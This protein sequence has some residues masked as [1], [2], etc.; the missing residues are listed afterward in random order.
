MTLRNPVRSL[1][2]VMALAGV[3][4]LPTGP[5][6]ASAIDDVQ[7][8]YRAYQ[9]GDFQAAAEAFGLAIGSGELTQDQMA[10]VLNNRGAAL[11]KAGRYDEAIA[12]YLKARQL[13]PQTANVD[14][15]LAH[16]YVQRGLR[17]VANGDRDRALDDYDQALLIDPDDI[18]ALRQRGLLRVEMHDLVGAA[19]DLRHV[20][21]LQPNDPA[22]SGALAALEGPPAEPAAGGA[23]AGPAAAMATVA[24]VQ[25]PPP[26]APEQDPPA[27]VVAAVED[28]P[29]PDRVQPLA[30]PVPP[31]TAPPPMPVTAPPP[32]EVLSAPEPKV[33]ETSIIATAPVAAEPAAGPS[34]E[35]FR[36]VGAVSLRA[37]PGTSF[38]RVGFLSEGEIVQT[39]GQDDDWYR[40]ARADAA[41][42]WVHRRW[43][44]PVE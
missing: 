22:A 7:A 10:V 20:L 32:M 24:P 27:D 3:L 16:A 38:D 35:S 12:E 5:A 17:H 43:L 9:A 36:V 11:A 39:S 30:P 37:G 34:V 42:G 14:G 33:P 44:S 25:P 6:A 26:D 18:L 8:G 31:V 4:A 23:P 40:I 28:T 2:T 1:L 41:A 15:N 13:G 21:M 19:A 29:P